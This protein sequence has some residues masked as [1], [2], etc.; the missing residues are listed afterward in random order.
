MNTLSRIDN[1]PEILNPGKLSETLKK[2]PSMK[3]YPFRFDKYD[4]FMELVFEN[5][6]V[7]FTTFIIDDGIFTLTETYIQEEYRGK[8]L[9]LNHLLPVISE[10]RKV[11]VKQPTRDFVEVL[12]HYGFARKLNKNL[13]ATAL[14]F[15]IEKE[16]IIFSENKPHQQDKDLS[17]LYDSKLCSPILLYDITTPG[18]CDVGYQKM[19]K[20][21]EKYCKEFRETLNTDEY[22]RKFKEDF[23]KNQRKYQENLFELQERIIDIQNYDT[24]LNSIEKQIKRERKQGNVLAEGVKKRREYLKK[25]EDL[26]KDHELLLKNLSQPQLALC[27]SCYQPIESLSDKTCRV[28]GWNISN[29]NY[30]SQ[31][32]IINEIMKTNSQ[33][34]D[35]RGDKFNEF[36]NDYGEFDDYEIEYCKHDFLNENYSLTENVEKHENIINAYEYNQILDGLK[37]NSN[38][39]EV[40]EQ[41]GIENKCRI[42]N[43][44]MNDYI[45]SENY[46]LEYLSWISSC[47]TIKQLKE[48][49]RKYNLKVSGNK[50]E[51]I[52]RLIENG[53]LNELNETEFLVT[54]E[55]E[56]FY[57]YTIWIQNY[58]NSMSCF[59]LYDFGNY[60]IDHPN[61]IFKPV[62]EGYLDEQLKKAYNEK[63]FERLVDTLCAKAMSYVE[64]NELSDALN[65][66]LKLYMVKINPEYL[67][68]LEDYEFIEDANIQ[69]INSLLLNTNKNL[70]KIFNK[71][72]KKLKLDNA[73][74][75][76]KRALKYLMRLIDGEDSEKINQ[77]IGKSF[78]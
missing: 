35:L 41:K 57:N 78:K 16:N 46:G 4:I 33:I 61:A 66:E 15:E 17:F 73:K 69:N 2:Y 23:H 29:R 12:I 13:V 56:D 40:L 25:G 31:E 39:Y 76:K 62:F 59:N 6:V 38:I 42:G 49:L 28:C 48:K 14:P 20:D 37:Y 68:D 52:E 67:N 9:L 34:I 70:K 19:L 32:E 58:L 22:F 10:N 55:G 65:E 43:L 63:D 44:L 51:L 21:D 50:N 24:D 60:L 7:G 3:N 75:S 72:W 26:S 47:Y 18:I 45:E 71:N 1:K 74:I 30:L 8:Y 36:I 54:D 77:E 11:T 5:K 27:P 64:M 53:L